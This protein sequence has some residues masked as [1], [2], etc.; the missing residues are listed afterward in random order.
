VDYQPHNPGNQGASSDDEEG[1]GIDWEKITGYI[2]YVLGS[3]GRR[4]VIFLTVLVGGIAMTYAVFWMMPRSYH[5]ESQLLAQR[6][7]MIPT[8]AV[9][10]RSVQDL[11]APTRAAAE[12]VLRRDNLICSTTGIAAARAPR[13]SRAG[14]ATGSA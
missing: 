3:I 4:K 11:A 8:L 9:S 6:N 10:N 12:T 1:G 14:S 13:A 5:I 7:Q 2:R